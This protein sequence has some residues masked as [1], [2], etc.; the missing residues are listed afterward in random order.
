MPL[1]EQVIPYLDAL[2]PEA[3]QIGAVNTIVFRDHKH[4]GYC[5]DGIGALNSLEE[6]GPVVGKT[7]LLL[8]AGGAARAIAFEAVKRGAKVTLFNRTQERAQQV[9]AHIDS[10]HCTADAW[11]AIGR[12]AERYDILVNATP[13]DLPIDPLFIKPGTLAMDIRTR[14][15]LTPFL[16]AAQKQG[17]ICI[18]GYRMF[19]H[20]AVEQYRLWL[21]SSLDAHALLDQ[22]EAAARCAL[23]LTPM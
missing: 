12:Y 19:I 4:F 15:V 13:A 1:K 8:G 7:L 21:G 23:N 2:D 11:E 16:Q 22:L 18:P 3:E 17:A 5:T 9:A 14:P 6:L 20:Q 10:P